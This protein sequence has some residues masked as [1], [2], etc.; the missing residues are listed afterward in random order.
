MV[1]YQSKDFYGG[2]IMD[3]YNTDLFSFFLR[4]QEIDI[5]ISFLMIEISVAC[6]R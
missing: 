2:Q 1:Q 3:P 5:L 6:L 4:E